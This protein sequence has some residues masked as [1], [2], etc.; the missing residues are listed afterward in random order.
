MSITFSPNSEAGLDLGTLDTSTTARY[1]LNKPSTEMV[2]RDWYIFL[3]C[4]NFN[5]D[6]SI[7]RI[8]LSIVILYL[9]NFTAP[10]KS[11][12]RCDAISESCSRALFCNH[13]IM[14]LD[15]I[16]MLTTY[17]RIRQR[18][19]IKMEQA[20]LIHFFIISFLIEH[21]LYKKQNPKQLEVHSNLNC[22]KTYSFFGN[23]R[24]IYSLH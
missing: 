24:K 5:V 13:S 1:I 17:I 11:L 22:P 10:I 14:F 8:M 3:F 23:A 21:G 15:E 2:K 7:C 6:T 20:P 19:V 12:Y 4:E 16:T 9:I 18:K